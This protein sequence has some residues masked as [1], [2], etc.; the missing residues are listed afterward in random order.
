MNVSVKQIVYTLRNQS[1]ESYIP[2]ELP[3]FV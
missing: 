3:E 2:T 1:L